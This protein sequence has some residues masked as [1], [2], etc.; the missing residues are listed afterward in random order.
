MVEHERHCR[1][2]AHQIEY[3]RQLCTVINNTTGMS[4]S[5]AVAVIARTS[6]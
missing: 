3:R 6:G 4:K 2:R 5:P 1:E